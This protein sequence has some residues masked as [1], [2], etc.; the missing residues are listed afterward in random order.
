MFGTKGTLNEHQLTHSD[1]NRR[2]IPKGYQVSTSPI[3]SPPIC[4]TSWV[5][6]RSS[7]V[8][9]STCAAPEVAVMSAAEKKIRQFETRLK[10]VNES[11]ARVKQFLDNYADEQKSEVPLRLGRLEK[12]LETF[13][14]L[15]AQYEQ[16]DDTDVFEKGCLQQRASVEELYFKCKAHLLEKLPPE[17]P[18]TPAP[19]SEASRPAL[20]SGMS[21]VKLP[22][23]TLPE[24][25]GDYSK[26]LTFHD[27]FLSLIHSSSEI[28]CVQ[29]FHYLRSSLVGEAAGKIANQEISAQGYAIAWETLT[30]YYNDKNLLRKK[31]IRTLLKYPKIPNDSVEALHRIVDDF[32]CHTQILK[33]LGEPVEQMSSILMELLEDKLDDASLSA[34]EESIG[35]KEERPTFNAMIEFLQRRARV[36]ETIQI[37]RPQQVAPKSG[38]HNSAPKKPFQ[39]RVCL[40]AAVESPPKTFPLCPACDKQKH[41]I[42]DCAAF[43]SMNVSER[44]RVVTDKRL[45]S[46]CFRSDHF[47]R[48]CRSK[49]HCKQCN[50]RHHSMIHP[51]PGSQD[52]NPVVATPALN[53]APVNAATKSSSAS[54]LLST[55]VLAVLDSYGK[56]HLARALLDTG[57]QPNVMSE[58]LCQQLHLFRKVANV[59][60]SGVDSTITNAKHMV[61]TE[62]RSRVSRFAETLDFLVLRKV[63]CETPPVT[64]PIAQWKIPEHLALA[65]PEF[66]VSRKV[67]MIIGAAHFYSFLLE[68]RIRLAGPVPLLVESVFGWIATG[69]VEV[70][71]EAEQQPTVSCHVATVESVDKMLERF[72][73][74]EEV[75]GSNYSVDEHKCEA[76]FKETVARDESGRYVVKLPKHPEFQQMI[77]ASKTNAVRR[78][79]WLEQKLEKQ[80]ELKPQ[81]HEFMQEYLTL[82]HMHAVPDDAED[83]SS[84]ACYLPHHPVIKEQSSTTKVRVVFDGSAKTSAGHSLNDALLVGPVVQDELLDTVL[85]FRKFPIALVT[86][87]EKMY[88]QVVVH[89]EDRPYQRIV[90]RFDPE[91]PI[92]T[93]ELATVTYGLAPSSFLAT[94]TLLQLA[95]D[96]GAQ[97][98]QASA[99]IKKHMYV[100]DFIGGAHTVDDAILLRSDLCKLLLKGGFQLRKWCSNSLAVLA[101]IP[102]ELLGTQSSLQFDPEETIKTLGISWE[103]EADVFRFVASVVWDLS[104]TKRNILSVIA[105]LY[106][107]LGLIAPVVV[108]AKIVLQ[109]LWYLA[110][111]WD[112]LVPPELRTRW[113]DFCEGLS[114]LNNFRIDRYAFARKCCYAELHFFSD[115]S[116]VAYGAVAYVRSE[117]PDGKI[118]VSLLTS[119]S[120]VAPLKKRSIPR[121]E[122]CAFFLAAQMFV[123]VVEAL[124]VKF[125]DVYFWTDSEVVLQWLKSAPRRWKPFV[126]NRISEIQIITHGAKCLHVA[127]LENP[128]DLVSRGMP[129]EK[130]VNSPKWKFGASW[131]G[132]HKPLWP[133]QRD[134][135]GAL[136]IEEQKE[137]PILVVQTAPPNHVFTIFFSYR[138]LLNAVGL[139]LRF[140]NNVR[141]PCKRNTDRVLSVVELEAAK[142]ALVKIVQAE[143]F[144]EDLK[145]L[146]KGRP[147]APKSP[148]RLLNPF[149]D[150]AGVIRVGG[151]LCLS[152]EPYAVKHPMVIPG[153]H[154]FTRLMLTYYHLKVIHGGITV[155]LA[156][157]RDEFWPLNGRRAVRNA[158]RRCF[159]CCRANPQPIQQPIGQLPVARVTANEAFTCTGVDF[160]GPLYLKP[161]HR[162]AASR[163]CYVAV[164]ICLST[165]AVH[166]ELVNDLSTA[167]FLMALTRFTWRRNKPSH[168]Y[169]DNGTNFIGAKNVLHQLYQMLQPGPESDKI[170]KH[171][172]DDGIQWHLIPPRAPN[173]GGLWEAAV[174]VAKKHLVRQL[175]NSLLSFEELTTVL[176]AIEGCMNSRPLTR[177]SED[178]ND[179][180]A[181]TPAHFLVKNMIRPLPEPDVRDVPLNRLNQYQRIQAYSQRFWHRWRNEYL[182][183]L[184]TQYSSNP[185]RY[186]LDVGSVVIIKDELLPPARWPLARVLEVHPGP[187]G[188]TRVATLRTA[189]GILK[190]AV[191]KICPL[192]CADEGEEEK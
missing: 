6:T 145:L 38:S 105:Q 151:R 67:D 146:R 104:P 102:S 55:V 177:L 26:W 149:L 94:R 18:R 131:L 108:L 138:R 157:V 99:A 156:S 29:K 44:L 46:N 77:G 110:L 124:D 179:L 89:P 111:E 168:I 36:R 107:P 33:Q 143:T 7:L 23:I 37:N 11:L 121:L 192:E 183:E 90:W 150:Q 3:K 75:G 17:E 119:K 86:D 96:E 106:D 174:K 153:F 88:R 87:I 50:K 30:K 166:L 51:G 148:L 101:D 19:N 180:S 20:L 122:L 114:H 21:N 169:S 12:T 176:T 92:T 79:R 139:A 41:S 184:Q 133:P 66:N 134:L 73:A 85:R 120:K 2:L 125:Q 144:P 43:N 28:S 76:H 14:S 123:R 103:P 97:F 190:R 167:A 147:V 170:A 172:A 189:G 45:C 128:A 188:V 132:K 140:A 70:S 61:R 22:T 78:F 34:W 178:P 142:V 187:D 136:P 117:S 126:A 9:S 127:G 186:D 100:D 8:H 113:F 59:P 24:F 83:E 69:S 1:E 72:W 47:A 175:G 141:K 52:T 116:E 135:K 5:F 57:S 80:P 27:T 39:T 158:I 191:S 171:L 161:T 62:V 64:I 82:G 162:R 155:T 16:L 53:P 165:K 129:A 115:A 63:T 60:I 173:F 71:D 91:Q 181:L 95:D 182:K 10:V 93:Y 58:H 84:R 49:Y 40:N 42:M 159:R 160:C 65:D 185:R 54:V 163:K 68:G 74:L 35:Q 109:E 137:K 31:H 15:M 164:F 98:P 118:K 56:E 25:D 32:Q 154:P 112:A 4:G 81:Y 48:N 152:D 13:E 130:L